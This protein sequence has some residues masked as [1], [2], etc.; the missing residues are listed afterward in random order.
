MA[1][2]MD[3]PAQCLCHAAG[4]VLRRRQALQRL[5]TQTSVEAR[6]KSV[7]VLSRWHLGHRSMVITR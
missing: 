7:W 6:E 5:H 4:A 2:R 1:S 3:D